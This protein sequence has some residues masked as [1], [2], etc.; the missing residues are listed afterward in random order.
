MLGSQCASS[1]GQRH[2]LHDA[3][4]NSCYPNVCRWSFCATKPSTI[5]DNEQE[6]PPSSHQGLSEEHSQRTGGTRATTLDISLREGLY[7]GIHRSPPESKKISLEP[8][9]AS[10][11]EPVR[12]S[13]GSC[14]ATRSTWSL[15]S[16]GTNL[17]SS[18][19]KSRRAGS[20]LFTG[21]AL[22]SSDM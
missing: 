3:S 21:T 19:S 14:N 16:F 17:F 5:S 22:S 11:S 20:S 6:D 9:P 4:H 15:T 7:S 18:S 2:T 12:L 13:S 8:F 10:P 1:Y